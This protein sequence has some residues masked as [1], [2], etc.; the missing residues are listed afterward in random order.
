MP[1]EKEL[2]SLDPPYEP[3]FNAATPGPRRPAY[4]GVAKMTWDNMA[5]DNA[6][7]AQRDPKLYP[8]ASLPAYPLYWTPDS[9]SWQSQGYFGASSSE[10]LS[11]VCLPSLFGTTVVRLCF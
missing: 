11:K 10:S 2:S 5:R 6:E 4:D 9:P 7:L 1:L 8:L 3:A